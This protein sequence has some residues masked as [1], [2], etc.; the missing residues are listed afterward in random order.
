MAKAKGENKITLNEATLCEIV[1]AWLNSGGPF[2]KTPVTILT[3]KG[4]YDETYEFTFTQGAPVK[5]ADPA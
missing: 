5:E 1:S 2:A 3:V 4:A